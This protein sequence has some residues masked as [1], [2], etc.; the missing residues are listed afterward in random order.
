MR[1]IKHKSRRR[2]DPA[3]W[4]FVV[5]GVHAVATAEQ[6]SEIAEAIFGEELT[7]SRIQLTLWDMYPR[8]QSCAA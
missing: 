5:E 6:A 8:K 7:A 1:I 4:Y 2:R 3:P